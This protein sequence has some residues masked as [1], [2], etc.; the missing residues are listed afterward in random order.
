[1]CFAMSPKNFRSMSEHDESTTMIC[2]KEV[3]LLKVCLGTRQK[4]FRKPCWKILPEGQKCLPHVWKRKK[5]QNCF[6]NC[7][8]F[9]ATF[10]F[11]CWMQLWQSCRKNFAGRPKPF[12]LSAK[13]IKK[14]SF[15]QK[16]HLS[17]KCFSGTVKSTFENH[18]K[19]FL[20][21][22][23]KTFA[24]HPKVINI[25]FFP[26]FFYSLCTSI[27]VEISLENP[28]RKHSTDVQS[29]FNQYA[30]TLKNHFFSGKNFLSNCSPGQVE[31]NLDNPAETVYPEGQKGFAIMVKLFQSLS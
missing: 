19:N 1:M 27:H 10:Q 28:L 6:Q 16:K 21:R 22:S 25:S 12:P 15:F 24:Q 23:R 3:V 2:S 5:M 20:T 17:L 29:F 7:I 30:K 26:K 13:V 4:Q 18:V 31:S 11:T 9:L 14:A 8:F